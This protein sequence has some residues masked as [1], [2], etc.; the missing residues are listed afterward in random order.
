MDAQ[1]I[2][3]LPS[4]RAFATARTIP[5]SLNEPEGLQPSNLP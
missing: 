3:D 5:R 4:S 1:M 2:A